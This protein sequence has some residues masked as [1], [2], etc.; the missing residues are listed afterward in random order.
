[1]NGGCCFAFSA[2]HDADSGDHCDSWNPLRDLSRNGSSGGRRNGQLRDRGDA[3]LTEPTTSVT[4]SPDVEVAGVQAQ[5]GGGVV[6]GGDI[7]ST[8][9]ARDLQF[10]QNRLERPVIM[11][12]KVTNWGECELVISANSWG[13]IRV[14]RQGL[15]DASNGQSWIAQIAGG[16]TVKYSCRGAEASKM[17][18]FTYQMEVVQVLQS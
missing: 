1:V 14:Q 11:V 16:E 7:K 12:W 10:F 18:A 17:C 15:I 2:A 9:N 5:A 8:C 6:T 13:D 3:D 4:L